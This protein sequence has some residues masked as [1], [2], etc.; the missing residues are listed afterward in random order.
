M[1]L[2]DLETPELAGP[3]QAGNFMQCR[4]QHVLDQAKVMPHL[5]RC[6]QLMLVQRQAVQLSF[7]HRAPVHLQLLCGC[8]PV[9]AICLAVLVPQRELKLPNKHTRPR[10]PSPLALCVA[11]IA[12][13]A[14]PWL[15]VL[16]VTVAAILTT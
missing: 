16:D 3:L 11:F 15:S 12:V 10:Y 13:S 14:A 6:K 8:G 2:Q 5:R 9:V 4:C 7:S 1:H